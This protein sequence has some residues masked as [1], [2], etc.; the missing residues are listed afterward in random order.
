[1]IDLTDTAIVVVIADWL[2]PTGQHSV[3][4]KNPGRKH[5]D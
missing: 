5:I 3:F 1:M 4:A 2:C